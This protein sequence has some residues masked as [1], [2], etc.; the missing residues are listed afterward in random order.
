M[1]ETP[2]IPTA[3]AV[4]HPDLQ[5]LSD[6]EI[7]DV[8]IYMAEQTD[9]EKI[10]AGT[11]ALAGPLVDKSVHR[12]LVRKRI[13]TDLQETA[14]RSQARLQRLLDAARQKGTVQA[15]TSFFVV[16]A[17]HVKA[18]GSVIRA[19]AALPEVA[20]V[21]PNGQ[22]TL[23]L[24]ATD[25][26]EVTL[27]DSL[28][29]NLE[30]VGAALAWN[31]WNT[32]GEGIV[33]G[34]IDT[35][36]DWQHPALK[37]AWRG[38]N[39]AQP[40]LPDPVG[41]WYDVVDPSKTM[42]HDPQGHGTHVTGTVLGY[43]PAAD[44]HIGVAPA[45]RWI[46]VNAFVGDTAYDSNLIAAGEYMLAPKDASGTPHPE[47]APDIINNSWGTSTF[48]SFYRTMVQNW[49][50]A[51]ILPVFAAGNS[52]PGENSINVPGA[53][54]ESL[55]VGNLTNTDGLNSTSSRGPGY[56]AG[57]NKPDGSAPGTGIWSSKPGNSYQAMTGTSMA[58]PHVSGIAALVWAKHPELTV[59]EL[60]FVLKGTALP[61]M[62]SYSTIPNAGFG[63]GRI[64]ADRALAGLDNG[65]W[66][67]NVANSKALLTGGFNLGSHVSVPAA[68]HSWPVTQIAARALQN[69]G[70]EQL[71]L[72]ASIVNIA[73]E[74]FAENL[75]T[76]LV[77]PDSLTVLGDRALY[78]NH[79][80]AVH[81]PAG[82]QSIGALALGNN[83]PHAADLVVY[84]TLGTVAETYA[85]QNGHTF[86]DPQ[87]A[88]IA[89]STAPDGWGSVTGAGS[90]ATGASVVLTA[91]PNNGYRFKHW[92]EDTLVYG[93]NPLTFTAGGNRSLIAVFR[94][95]IATQRL[96]GTN[97]YL[98]AVAIS[99][100]GWPG[101]AD[102]VV[103]ARGD[104]FADAL[105]G[106]PLAYHL[107]API[108]LTAPNGLSSAVRTE[109]QRLGAQQV[110]I[111]GGS[112]AIGESVAEELLGM[113]LTVIR[114]S[115]GN[116]YETAATI[117]RAL[118]GVGQETDTALLAVGT[119]FPDA[120]AAAVHAARNGMPIL[121]TSK[122]T[123][124]GV[125]Q[126]VLMELAIA[127]VL[128][129]GGPAAIAPEV[130]DQLPQ[131]PQTGRIY[132]SNRYETAVALA[133]YFQ[134]DAQ[135]VWLATGLDFPDAVA[136][137]VLAAR[138]GAGLLLVD[139]TRALPP[140]TVREYLLEQGTAQVIMLGGTGAICEALAAWF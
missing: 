24:A 91:Q 1:A 39:P 64:G 11:H 68:W 26:G 73:T 33:V 29:W 16:N 94:E 137:G 125:T 81:F 99:Q 119:Q 115:G 100:S 28:L 46:A 35:G 10:A 60:E 59:D 65:Y 109:I 103:L 53:H 89:I 27:A 138:Q 127:N 7:W 123:L 2:E 136:G 126:D 51:G 45:A 72:P 82:I 105:A 77:L 124:S 113:G 50:N 102:T 63:R 13:V 12:Q 37:Q 121:L 98:T 40:T 118:Q 9:T 86:I 21:V 90:Y 38:Y 34:I 32:R 108:L 106:T 85:R 52:G 57:V 114:L 71:Q 140:Y 56:Y 97:R 107:N 134:P 139:G 20:K 48:S 116:R 17:M 62:G 23:S 30:K 130:Y 74:A 36:V 110:Y 84:G 61:L 133:Q 54:P 75:L 58:A 120:L 111:L 31:Q 78:G 122:D 104:Q 92:L 19:M 131:G 79:L 80:Q 47:W 15:E 70:L 83:Q 43:D 129:V 8:L 101:G 4:I 87:A 117:A 69:K 6:E 49:R 128:V 5:N 66:T 14:Q 22:V 41:N 132:G 93:E 112:A 44:Y 88:V 95:Q 3:Q 96:S 25:E 76:E 42:P 55:A 135:F 18:P 67:A